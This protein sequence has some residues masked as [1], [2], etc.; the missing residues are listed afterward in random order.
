MTT[1]LARRDTHLRLTRLVVRA[2]TL[3]ALAAGGLAAVR[4]AFDGP[5]SPPGIALLLATLAF[6]AIGRMRSLVTEDRGTLLGLVAGTTMVALAALEGGV[7]SEA[8][9]WMPLVPIATTFVAGRR[10]GQIIGGALGVGLAAVA[11]FGP[12]P[13][14]TTSESQLLHA[15]AAFAALGFAVGLAGVYEQGR[16]DSWDALAA[17]E[18]G[19]RSLLGAL[20]I[21][22][23][24]HELR[25]PLTA[26]HGAL[27]LLGAGA[28]GALPQAAE[29]LVAAGLR[30]TARLGRLADQLLALDD[31][32][33]AVRR[34]ERSQ[35]R[36]DDLLSAVVL[37]EARRADQLRV[38][39]GSRGPE[40]T[41]ELD[42]YR[43]R[44]ILKRLVDNAMSVS[45]SDGGVELGAEVTDNEILLRVDDRGPGIPEADR[46]RVFAPFSHVDDG[47]VR[48]VEGS[49]LGLY[50][51]RRMAERMGGQLN[52][53]PRPDGG[54][55]FELRL[56]RE[57]A[58]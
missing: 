37:A 22:M 33:R 17:S 52:F 54:T 50:V 20:P 15:A 42:V 32:V 53:R 36:L 41:V 3:S 51:A 38:R 12:V 43:V 23:V 25:T 26:A 24:Q 40:A 58:V 4:F 7:L 35:V 56:P 10:R 48:P 55:R 8:I 27:G 45:P 28:G 30:S 2:T 18:E 34:P 21:T 29:R 16:Q 14:A 1:H 11:V 49:G 13:P 31:L 6:A 46:E 9:G 5:G 44:Q 19:L 57:R 47:S 39:L